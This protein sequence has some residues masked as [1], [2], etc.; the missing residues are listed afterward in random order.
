MTCKVM[1][2]QVRA[3]DMGACRR[4]SQGCDTARRSML[5]QLVAGNDKSL[6]KNDKPCD[7]G[8]CR[9]LSQ[10]FARRMVD[11]QEGGKGNPLK[12]GSLP[13]RRTRPVAFGLSQRWEYRR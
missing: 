4:L 9:R 1:P 11:R 8:A 3:C 7:T 12:G 5:S 2:P 13:T 10:L 6:S